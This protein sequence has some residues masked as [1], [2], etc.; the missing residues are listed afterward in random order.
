MTT[1]YVIKWK[2]LVNGRA[3]KGTR[4]FEK[5]EA[6]QLAEELN[7]EYPQIQHVAVPVEPEA[8]SRS[9]ARAHRDFAEAA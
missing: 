1:S 7:R 8:G 3:G 2:S 6:E 5:K 4:H 9:N